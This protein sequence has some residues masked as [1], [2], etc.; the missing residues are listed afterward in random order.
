MIARLIVLLA[1]LCVFPFG[2]AAQSYPERPITMTIPFIAGGTPDILARILADHLRRVAN[3]NIVI[4]NRGGANGVIGM[5]HA[6]KATPDGYNLLF[7]STS[8]ATVN[9]ALNPKLPYDTTRDFEPVMLVAESGLV[10]Q[11]TN[12]L[13]AKTPADVVALARQKPGALNFGSAGIGNLTH[14]VGELF[15]I[16][17]KADITHIPY[18]GTAQVYPDLIAGRVEILFDTIPAG[19]GFIRDK[20]V[21]ALAVTTNHRTVALPD[22][23]TM[24]ELGIGKNFDVTAWFAMMAPKGTPPAVIQKLNADLNRVLADPAV[25]K[26]IADLGLDPVG[27]EAAALR[28]KIEVEIPRWKSVVQAAGVKLNQ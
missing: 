17:T 18:K 14:L 6:A 22:T 26:Q 28:H 7:V 1:A 19:I 9:A 10:M 12:S 21:R 5:E 13:P 4:D 24:I 27:G 15:K 3:Y 16:E 20:Q 25:R 23:P 8:P 2:A 11:V